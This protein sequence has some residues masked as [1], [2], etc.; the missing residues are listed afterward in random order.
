MLL[1]REKVQIMLTVA[2]LKLSNKRSH[3]CIPCTL[4]NPTEIQLNRNIKDVIG[5]FI[6]ER[7]C[8]LYSLCMHCS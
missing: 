1:P 2:L 8:E 4:G 6:V 5:G 3:L 7:H